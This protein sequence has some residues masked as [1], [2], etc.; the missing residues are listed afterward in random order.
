MEKP[1][2]FL[3]SFIDKWGVNMNIHEP[4]KFIFAFQERL[5]F[6]DDCRMNVFK[7]AFLIEF[8]PFE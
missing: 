4:S 5:D 8:P 1:T 6:F 3:L 2:Y 7:A